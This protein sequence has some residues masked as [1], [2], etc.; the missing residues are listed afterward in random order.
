MLPRPRLRSRPAGR[1]VFRPSPPLST[2]LSPRQQPPHRRH[3]STSSA[4][5]SAS[6]AAAA[7]AA[8]APPKVIFSGIQPTGVPHLGNYLGALK[9]WVRLQDEE[10]R[11]AA[12][13]AATKL[14]YSVVDLHAITVPQRDAAALR[15]QRRE[16]L[17]ALLA[18]GLDPA[19]SAIFYQS[20]VSQLRFARALSF[21]RSFVRGSGVGR[22]GHTPV[23]AERLGWRRG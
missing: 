9:S 1:L 11:G 7:A 18:V 14:L 22:T 8:A 17:A 16:M 13:A 12:A 10:S 6:A 5:A 19:R 21:V 20:S 3:A 15:R 23:A 2:R 4:S